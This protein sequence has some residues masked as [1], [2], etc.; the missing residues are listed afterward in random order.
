[1]ERLDPGRCVEVPSAS[2]EKQ[3][4]EEINILFN[5]I[6]M[7][8]EGLSILENNLK[9]VLEDR[10]EPEKKTTEEKYLVPLA[11]TIRD[12]RARVE[13]NADKVHSI[14]NRLEL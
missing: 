10:P 8:D 11:A 6:N 2:K 4:N 1:M 12:A 9:G 7:L 5:S 3:V 13:M 14:L